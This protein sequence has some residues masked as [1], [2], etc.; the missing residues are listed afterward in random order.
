MVGILD[1]LTTALAAHENGQMWEEACRLVLDEEKSFPKRG[2][3]M[4]L[5]HT[6]SDSKTA[7]AYFDHYFPAGISPSD[8]A[9][10]FKLAL[11]S[12]NPKLLLS[13]ARLVYNLGRVDQ[14]YQASALGSAQQAARALIEAAVPA[15]A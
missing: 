9:T 8:V 12:E 7:G 13:L 11:S 15:E 3:D 4:G 2:P 14:A 10:T 6:F 1:G 5:L